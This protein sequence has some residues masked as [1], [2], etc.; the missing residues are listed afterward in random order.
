ME[1][2]EKLGLIIPK[3]KLSSDALIG[4]IDE[5]ILRE[6][7]D[8]GDHEYTLEQK[9]E[10]ITKQLNSGKIVILF[11]PEEESTNLVKKEEALK[12]KV[13]E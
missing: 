6:G 9:R 12:F 3:E 2:N 13:L 5:F 10:K 11:D 8:Y 1:T 4:L 7:T